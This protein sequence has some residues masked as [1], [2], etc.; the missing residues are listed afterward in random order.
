MSRSTRL[1]RRS[2]VKQIT[3]GAMIGGAASLFLSGRAAAVTDQDPND[4]VGSGSGNSPPSDSDRRDRAGF[5]THSPTGYTGYTDRDTA[6]TAYHG[7]Q[8]GVTRITDQDPTD[9]PGN[10][11]GP[12]DRVRQPPTGFSDYD[13]VDSDGYSPTPPLGRQA[14][15][16]VTDRDPSDTAG[17]GRGTGGGGPR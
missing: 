10:G 7:R 6:D 13:P 15:P 12:R 4:P 17:H 16:G 5:P 8:G 11:Y 3:G 14:N 9:R 2:F 1:N